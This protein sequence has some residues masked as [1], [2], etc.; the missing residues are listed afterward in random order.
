M[1]STCEANILKTERDTKNWGTKF[2]YIIFICEANIL[3]TEVDIKN[4]GK[5]LYNS[6]L[7]KQIIKGRLNPRLKSLSWQLV[8]MCV[9]LKW[10]PVSSLRLIFLLWDTSEALASTGMCKHNCKVTKTLFRSR[11]PLVL[12][13][14]AASRP[15]PGTEQAIDVHL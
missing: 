7:F 9:H 12:C 2:G 11:V 1:N 4:W 14:F 13:V 5:Y 8:E 15:V 6:Y 10:Q 3:K